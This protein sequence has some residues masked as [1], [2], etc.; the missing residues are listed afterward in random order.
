MDKLVQVLLL[1]GGGMEFDAFKAAAREINANPQLWLKAKHS[2]LVE[3]EILED[4]RLWI[5][6]AAQESV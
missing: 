4:G 1:N 2:G 5:R 3:T 6:V